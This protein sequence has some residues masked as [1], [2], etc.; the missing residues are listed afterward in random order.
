MLRGLTA[1]RFWRLLHRWAGLAFA[2]PFLVLGVTGGILAFGRDVEA[3]LTPR[4]FT[5]SGPERRVDVDAVLATVLAVDPSPVVGV[6]LPDAVWPVWMV[7]QG[8]GHDRLQTFVDPQS[9]AILGRRDAE[10]SL[11][12]FIRRLHANLAWGDDGRQLVGWI[13][14]VLAVMIGSGLVA[15]WPRAGEVR[16]AVTVQPGA[17][18]QR[19]LRELHNVVAIWPLLILLLVTLTGIAMAFPRTV[20]AMLEVPASTASHAMGAAIPPPET[21]FP[22]SGAEALRLAQAPGLVAVSLAI[23]G[24]DH[25]VWTVTLRPAQ[26]ISTARRQRA[27]DAWSGRVSPAAPAEG[28]AVAILGELH[29]LHGGAFLGLLGRAVIGLFGL[30][31]A[32]LV[33]TGSLAWLR[34]RRW[35]RP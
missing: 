6:Q 8:R 11:S 1:R 29:G 7:T 14:V 16:R 4:L 27:V 10:A 35:G 31:F 21:P 15:W 22:I 20:R 25:P 18:G 33:V 26:G 24:R 19:L 30:S 2:L 32:V 12:R 17:R 28:P 5:A 13:G 23:A 9:G 3:V 34:R